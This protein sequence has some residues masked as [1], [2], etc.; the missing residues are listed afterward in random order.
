MVNPDWRILFPQALVEVL[1]Q[2]NSDHNP[3]LLS[4][5][6]LVVD[7]WLSR[8]EYPNLVVDAWQGRTLQ[9]GVPLTYPY[10]PLIAKIIAFYDLSWNLTFQH[11]LREG[12]KI[13]DYLA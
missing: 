12:N 7:A 11:V 3:L 13:A 9:N 1:Y 6:K 8:P 5:S 4:C 10:A 2:H